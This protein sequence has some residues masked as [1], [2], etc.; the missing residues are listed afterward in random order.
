VVSTQSTTRYRNDIFFFFFFFLRFI[1]VVFIV[2]YIDALLPN[3]HQR[4]EIVLARSAV[5]QTTSFTALC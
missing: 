1:N 5:Q 2:K 4:A 3:R